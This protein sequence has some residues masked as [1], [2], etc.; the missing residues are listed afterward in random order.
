MFTIR[1]V[2]KTDMIM[3]LEWRN[4]IQVRRYMITQ[5]E[6]GAA[7]HCEWLHGLLSDPHRSALIVERDRSPMGFVQFNE[8]SH[9]EAHWGFYVAPGSPKGS[10]RGLARVALDYAFEL[11]GFGRVTGRAFSSNDASI[12]LHLSCGFR[13]SIDFEKVS[14]SDGR[15]EKFFSFTLDRDRWIM[16]RIHNE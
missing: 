1:H 6:I 13:Q 4:H 8:F 2:K 10:G 14:L 3:L 12:K 9:S 15:T 16:N 7:E 5:H 11:R